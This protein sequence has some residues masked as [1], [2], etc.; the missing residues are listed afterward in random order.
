MGATPLADGTRSTPEHRPSA[1]AILTEG[2]V[3]AALALFSLYGFGLT[4]VEELEQVGSI[5]QAMAAMVHLTG[6]LGLIAVGFAMMTR[7]TRI[8]GGPS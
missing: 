5:G 2:A 4:L 8:L 6:W 7:H 1:A 3:G